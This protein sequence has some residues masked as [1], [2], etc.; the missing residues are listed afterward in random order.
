VLG[1][2][3]GGVRGRG[4]FWCFCTVFYYENLVL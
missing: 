3:E 2:E 1:R 4:L